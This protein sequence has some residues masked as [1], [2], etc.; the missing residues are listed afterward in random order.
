MSALIDAMV[1]ESNAPSNRKIAGYAVDLSSR[2]ADHVG[3][4]SEAC[5]SFYSRKFN[6]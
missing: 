3:G 5:Y 4:N 2:S 6:A 1:P